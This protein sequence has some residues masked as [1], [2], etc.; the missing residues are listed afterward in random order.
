MA[1]DNVKGAKTVPQKRELTNVADV[2]TNKG[3]IIAPIGPDSSG[4]NAK[5]HEAHD[6]GE[7]A[8]KIR[9]RLRTAIQTRNGVARI[10]EDLEEGA[11]KDVV[12]EYGR[13]NP[14]E[15]LNDF[16][17]V[18][19]AAK[20][21]FDDPNLD[22]IEKRPLLRRRL[23]KENLVSLL[24]AYRTGQHREELRDPAKRKRIVE[25]GRRKIEVLDAKLA[26]NE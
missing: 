4:E 3:V 14:D 12:I 1:Q 11:A 21:V 23:L 15:I 5:M 26:E 18:S 2:T 8:R 17:E 13:D 24:D 19:V 16:K 10:A 22:E 6:I 7:L 9:P 20:A 25:A